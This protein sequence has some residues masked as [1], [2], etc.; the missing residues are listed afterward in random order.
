[1]LLD[2]SIF[3]PMYVPLIWAFILILSSRAKRTQLFLGIF[4]FVVFMIFLSHVVYFKHLKKIYLFFD[5]VFVLGSLSIYPIYYYYIKL[6]T[7]QSRIG[8]KDMKLLIPAVVMLTATVLTY[9]FMSKELKELYINDYLYGKGKLGEAPALIKI[10]LILC[11]MLQIIYFIQI[12]CYYIKI[13]SHI[14]TYN[15]QIANY[16][17]N[18][19]N[20]TL[21]WP[22]FILYSFVVISIVTV[23][24]NFMG[25]ST[26]DKSPILLFITCMAYSVLL[27][28]FGFLG[29]MQSHV[30]DSN[31]LQINPFHDIVI[32][33]PNH[34]KI[35]IQ[36]IKLFEQEQIFKNPDLKIT[37]IASKLSTNRTYISNI[38]NNDYACSF[39]TFVNRYRVEEAKKAL[40]KDENCGYCLEHISSQI[41]FG[42]LHT[43]IRVFKEITGSTPGRYRERVEKT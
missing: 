28:V 40:L 43:F 39:S 16:Y 17:S 11:Y 24:S 21:E 5:L 25:R 30:N 3:T 9:F 41:G 22:K 12:I 36:L 1:M 4:M 15:E 37:D 8:V 31:E 13:K 2:I 18:T 26:F 14:T 34:K 7:F 23:F 19:E 33:N 20:R 10:Q 42:S 38:I 6:L 35:K 29:Y 32:E 27:F